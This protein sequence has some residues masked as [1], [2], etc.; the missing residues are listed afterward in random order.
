MKNII[1]LGRKPCMSNTT[2]QEME[3]KPHYFCK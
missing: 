3:K 2:F 1:G